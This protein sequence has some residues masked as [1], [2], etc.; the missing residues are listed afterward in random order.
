MKSYFVRAHSQALSNGFK[1]N[2][3]VHTY[4]S[5]TFCVHCTGLLWGLIK[6]GV[7]CKQ[8]GIN[9]HKHCKDRVVVECRK[10]T[11][12]VVQRRNTMDSVRGSISSQGSN[13]MNGQSHSH[14]GFNETPAEQTSATASTSAGN[15]GGIIKWTIIKFCK[16]LTS[17]FVSRKAELESRTA[18]IHS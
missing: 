13:S 17:A 10:K 3:S 11:R 6:Q 16:P 12:N 9:A 1:H 15:L 8:C 7:K 4:F 14:Q 18:Q 2:F 5:P